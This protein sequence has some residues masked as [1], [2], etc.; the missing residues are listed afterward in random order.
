MR[1]KERKRQEIKW[2]QKLELRYK[3]ERQR[4]IHGILCHIQNVTRRENR[5]V[6]IRFQFR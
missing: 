5:I 2:G 6:L 1:E 3:K 4:K